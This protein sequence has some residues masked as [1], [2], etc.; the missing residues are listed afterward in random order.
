MSHSTIS[1]DLPEVAM[2]LA[3]LAAM[4]VLPSLGTAEV[5]AKVRTGLSTSMKRMLA[6][7]VFAELMTLLRSFL[8]WFF[9]RL[10]S[11]IG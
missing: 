3:R 10:N 5:M 1:T 9:L 8:A 2:A 6:S 11:A 7:R 4:K